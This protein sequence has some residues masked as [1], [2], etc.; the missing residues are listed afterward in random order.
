[1]ADFFN[2]DKTQLKEDV[3]FVVDTFHGQSKKGNDFYIVHFLSTNRSG[4]KCFLSNHFVDRSVYDSVL[5]FGYYRV[6]T[7][8]IHADWVSLTPIKAVEI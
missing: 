5:Y 2:K 8:G 1:M 6:K 4:D 7:Q 3:I